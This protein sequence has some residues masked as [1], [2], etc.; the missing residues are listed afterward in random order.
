MSILTWKDLYCQLWTQAAESRGT[1]TSIG[2]PPGSR[3]A[4][5]M[6]EW[7]RS[8]GADARAITSV[9][10]PIVAAVP[11]RPGG[12]GVRRLWQNAVVELEA[13]GSMDPAAEYTSNR[14]FWAALLAVASY[15]D[16]T[17]VPMP[18]PDEIEA[19]LDLLWAPVLHRNASAPS[20]AIVEGPAEKVWTAQ[21]D[22]L[23]KLR[24]ADLKEPTAGMGGR[25]MQIPRSTNA[26]IVRL[27]DYWTLQLMA[28][29]PAMIVAGTANTMGLE[30]QLKRWAGIREDVD[31]TARQGKPDDVYPKNHQF[32]HESMGLAT[33]LTTWG[34]VPSAFELAFDATQKAVADLPS[35]LVGAASS[36][37]HDISTD[38]LSEIRKDLLIGGGVLLGVLLVFS[39]ARRG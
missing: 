24:G 25:A 29:L 18:D 23:I 7:P 30:G 6:P 39:V 22:E 5:P 3:A 14:S 16:T 4:L 37:I 27:T 13:T 31:A 28:F 8:V 32:W 36:F 20:H 9:V 10:D 33:N 21:R 26:D 12:Y 19:L 11:L 17:K 2:A 35:R 38:F 34:E 15:L 1:V